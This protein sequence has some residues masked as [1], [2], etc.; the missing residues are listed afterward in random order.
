MPLDNR[1]EAMRQ[2]GI[3]M[4][5]NHKETSRGGLAVNIPEC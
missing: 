4:S 5:D 3:N 1:I 2:T